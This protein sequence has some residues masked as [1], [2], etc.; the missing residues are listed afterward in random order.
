M[1]P[2]VVVNRSITE[3]SVIFA[4][5]RLQTLLPC[6]T[7]GDACGSMRD[8]DFGLAIETVTGPDPYLYPCRLVFDPKVELQS[9]N[10]FLKVGGACKVD[11]GARPGSHRV[12]P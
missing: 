3:D 2:A 6:I 7:R 10:H 4:V 11:K 12:M 5:S 9:L 1:F 8:L